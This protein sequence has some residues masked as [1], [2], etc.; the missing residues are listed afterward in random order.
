MNN[1]GEL[2]KIVTRFRPIN[3]DDI[4]GNGKNQNNKYLK[5]REALAG[6]QA[7]VEEDIEKIVGATRD[8]SSYRMF[9]LRFKEKLLNGLLASRISHITNYS[10]AFIK[11]SRN[12]YC[13]K[14]LSLLGARSSVNDLLEETLK[15]A[16][17]FEFAEIIMYCCQ[18]LRQNQ[19]YLLNLKK[20]NY[21]SRIYHKQSEILADENIAVEY[22]ELM[23]LNDPGTLLFSTEYLNTMKKNVKEIETFIKKHNTYRLNLFYFRI[24]ASLQLNSQDYSASLAT[25]NEF[26]DFIEKY[27]HF[28]YK[29]R[30]G[31]IL[32]QKM[33]CYLYL[34]DYKNGLVCAEQCSNTYEPGIINWF[35]YKELLLI[36]S[37]H[38]QN[39]VQA[40]LVI[41]EVTTSP[42][43]K[44]KSE[45]F[46]ERWKIFDAYYSILV[47]AGKAEAYSKA[48][49]RFSSFINSVGIHTKDKKGFNA[50]L[51]IMELMYYLLN[52]DHHII[53][54]KILALKVYSR[55]YFVA[56]DNYRSYTFIQLMIQCEKYRFLKS[57][58]L[59][60]TLP[61]QAKLESTQF[62]FISS[63]DGIE[64]VP[65]MDL[66]KI[67][68]EC[69]D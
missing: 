36:L 48:K 56:N 16:I 23:I 40:G 2:A 25:W 59:K 41:K 50:S 53:T 8:S 61:L 24:K 57:I 14:I 12:V 52:R 68:V 39:Y 62:T 33:H 29:N 63:L 45:S 11:L 43:L 26:S 9:K 6:D 20:F 46:K 37:L 47:M 21:Y 65:F 27:K 28:E 7:I 13:A 54:E 5:L 44:F 58:V 64:I 22:Y 30:M 51:I 19:M 49:F 66:W 31:E 35:L 18:A 15:K 38:T 1:F 69:L 32:I 17:E 60:K 67:V 4:F 42:Y 55:R 10:D 34:R 3:T